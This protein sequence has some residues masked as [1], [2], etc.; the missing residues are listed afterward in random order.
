MT[1]FNASRRRLLQHTGAVLGSSAAPL[2]LNM[3]AMGSAAAQSATDYKALVCVFQFGGNDPF[4]TVLATDPG[5]WSNYVAVRNQAPDS[6]ALMAP[7]VAAVPGAAVGSPA[8]LGGV[9]P[10]S[11]LRSQSRTY[12]L[13]PVLAV[14]QAKFNT[15][16]KLAI[17]SNVGPLIM[18]TTK[19]QVALVSHPK[20][21]KLFSHNDQQSVWQA[22]APEGSARGWGGRMADLLI[23][24][25]AQASF[26]AVSAGGQAI[27][28]SGQTARAYQVTTSGALRLGVDPNGT[29]YNSATV[30]AAMQRVASTSR[31]A[32]IL[33]AD[34]VAMARRSMDAERVL[35][36]A[37]K[38]ASDALWGTPAGS[39][40]QAAD[41]K[42]RYLS[43]LTS[44]T[45]ANPLAQQLQTVARM[46]DAGVALGN[47]RQVFFVSLGGFDTHNA[48]NTSHADLMARLGQAL[49]YFDS[50]LAAM[51]LRDKVTTFTASDF[52]RTFTSNGDG[53]DHGW[54]SHHMVMGGAVK[55]GDIYGS[56]PVLAAKN[57]ND[58]NFDGSANQLLNGVLLPQTSV[59]QYAA[60]MGRWFGLSDSQLLDVLPNLANF[61][62]AQRQLGF[63]A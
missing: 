37:L 54:G 56:F 19:A 63:M 60:T 20:P 22:F 23:T 17:V 6:I 41:P 27:W 11:P 48:Q 10:I 52:G 38:P 61:D 50:T 47:R 35:S 49:G 12:A 8:R 26:T 32:H 46:I 36:G 21:S 24:G 58:N 29:L 18:P 53:T 40:S 43:P 33:E 30:G 4:N 51:G 42:L 7:G 2:A 16:R 39:Y 13:H 55:G 3:M 31:S 9:L 1:G 62:L 5:S 45:A 15:D 34:Y 14:L 25:N 57:S 59:E 44:A 28:L